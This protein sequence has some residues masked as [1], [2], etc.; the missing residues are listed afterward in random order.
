MRLEDLHPDYQEQARRQVE[1]PPEQSPVLQLSSK[2][3]DKAEKDLQT[4]CER[5][6]SRNAIAFL[7]ISFR[8]REKAGW[9]DLVFA[10]DGR[11][12]AVEL[13]AKGG[14]LSTDQVKMLTMM[15]VN[16]WEVYVLRSYVPFW[17]LLNGLPQTQ[18]EAE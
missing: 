11:P 14:K 3:D 2:A 18:W 15:K 10:L 7:H 5:E 17:G 6:L 4:V 1:G 9:P 12:I 16:G 13:K 8:A